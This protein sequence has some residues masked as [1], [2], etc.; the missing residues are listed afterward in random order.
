MD[1]TA[2]VDTS[3]RRTILIVE[4]NADLRRMFR[5]YLSLNAFDVLEAGDGLEALRLLDGHAPPDLVVLDLNLPHIPGDAVR[6]EI[7]AHAQTR[8]IPIVIVTASDEDLV[9]LHV[10]C[11]LRKPVSPP[12]L[13]KTVRRCLKAGSGG[14]VGSV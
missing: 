3:R 2:R 8:D 13:L 9:H 10:A 1:P 6:W 5:L 12:E 11:V 14:V 4:D 7:A